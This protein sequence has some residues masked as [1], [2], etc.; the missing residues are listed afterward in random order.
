MKHPIYGA[1]YLLNPK[2]VGRPLVS[3]IDGECYDDDLTVIL[4][5][6]MGEGKEAQR[7]AAMRDFGKFRSNI[8]P[9]DIMELAKGKQAIAGFIWWNSYCS[10]RLPALQPTAVKILSK[11]TSASG[12][13]RGWSSV[14]FTLGKRRCSLGS[15]RLGKLI[16]TRQ[17]LH[18]LA[19]A[20]DADDKADMLAGFDV[21]HVCHEHM[22]EHDLLVPV[23]QDDEL[24]TDAADLRTAADFLAPDT[25]QHFDLDDL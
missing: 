24:L 4:T 5:R 10:T 19:R 8:I 7:A 22:D 18:N 20:A 16:R 25:E 21:K 6:Y 11:L 17:N 1:A 2:Y 9:R 13:E 15:T 3:V 23:E 14:D 12:C